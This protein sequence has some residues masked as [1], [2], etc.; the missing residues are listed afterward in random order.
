MKALIIGSGSIGLRHATSLRSL[1]PSVDITFLREGDRADNATVP[2]E[3]C[4]LGFSLEKE[5]AERPDL[6]VIA[7]PSSLHLRYLEAVINHNIPFYAEKPLVTSEHD[8]SALKKIILDSSFVPINLVGC[9]L[10]FLPSLQAVKEMLQAGNI[11]KLVR[12][13]F[14]AGQWLPD[15]R[16]QQDYT[17]SYSAKKELGGGVL[18]DL[19]HEIDAAHWLLGDFESTCGVCGKFSNLNIETTDVASILLS[20]K[21]GPLV[22]IQ[23]DYVSRMPVRNYTFVGDTGT[24]EWDLPKKQLL[25][26]RSKQQTEETPFDPIDYDVPRTYMTAMNEL[27]TAIDE[28]R[29]TSQSLDDGIAALETAFNVTEVIS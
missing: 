3:D 24:I 17:Q 10:R 12:T 21:S 18:L 14:V 9:N 26:H 22:S 7:N 2:L 4:K 13:S 29:P 6:V 8:L 1:R 5:L 27:L 23:L 28:G 16:P 15:W 11:G 20:R 19:I 25:I